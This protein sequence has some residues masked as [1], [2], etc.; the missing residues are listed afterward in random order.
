VVGDNRTFVV[1]DH[2]QL[3]HVV[4]KLLNPGHQYPM[5]S[6]FISQREKD[7]TLQVLFPHNNIHQSR[8]TSGISLQADI[9][10]AETKAPV[11]FTNG[12]LIAPASYAHY[13]TNP[14]GT[15]DHSVAWGSLSAQKA[16]RIIYSHLLFTFTDLVCIFSDDYPD[17]INIAQFLVDCIQAPPVSSLPI[18]AQPQVIVLVQGNPSGSQTNSTKIN[19]FKKLGKAN[20]TQVSQWFSTIN[21]IHL[22]HQA[23]G[24][25]KY[26]R[27]KSWIQKYR[28]KI[29]ATHQEC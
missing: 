16:L 18:T 19:F 24:L 4:S 2:S 11:L 3:R 21:L 26:K 20:I 29:Q 15:T 12:D 6:I 5:L 1:R 10:T 23:T 9:L 28:H 14:P 8:S 13:L 22:D 17:L 25:T 7:I 27:L